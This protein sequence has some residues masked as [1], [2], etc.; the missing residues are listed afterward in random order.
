M[1]VCLWDDLSFRV[2]YVS[3]STYARYITFRCKFDRSTKKYI[4]CVNTKK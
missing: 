4:V 2:T 3:H 1:Y